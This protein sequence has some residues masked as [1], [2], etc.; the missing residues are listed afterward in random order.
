MLLQQSQLL[1]ELVDLAV[2]RAVGFSRLR[3]QALLEG[4]QVLRQLL[5]RTARGFVDLAAQF[6]LRVA[7]L[8]D[9]GAERE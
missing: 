4:G 7:A 2:L 6:A 3:L 1:A 5:A 8:G 9:F